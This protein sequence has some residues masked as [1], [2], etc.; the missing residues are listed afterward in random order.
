M[1]QQVAAVAGSLARRTVEECVGLRVERL[2][3][4]VVREF[5]HRL[6]PL[7]LSLPQLEILSALTMSAGAVRPSVVAD[8]LGVERSTMSRNLALLQERGWVDTTD[9]S[10]SGRSLAVAI[11]G[12]GTATLAAAEQAWTQTQESLVDRLGA[13][14][15]AILDTWLSALSPS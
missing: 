2:H 1:Q 5:E 9:T 4:L 7:G 11:T 15:P 12:A 14:T 13:D 3:R 10:A 6:R 8:L